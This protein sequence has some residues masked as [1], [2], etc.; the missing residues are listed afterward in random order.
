MSGYRDWDRQR[1][2]LPRAIRLLL[3]RGDIERKYDGDGSRI[4]GAI[5]M[6]AVQNGCDRDW[7][8]GLLNDPRNKGGFVA[9]QRR[10]GDL[11]RW[12]E[13]DWER[14]ERK[15]AS[16]PAILDPQQA[17]FELQ[18]LL[19]SVDLMQWSG[20]AGATDRAVYQAAV[21]L[22]QKAGRLNRVTLPVRQLAEHALVSAGTASV[23]L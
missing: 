20:R 6:A 9:L 13:G 21:R 4:I 16:E 22:A 15:V 12:F 14:A 17:L 3:E 10:R 8:F 2:E 23:S 7:I 19:D 11:R 5:I 18:Q 1:T